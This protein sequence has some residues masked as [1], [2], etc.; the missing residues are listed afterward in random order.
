MHLVGFIIR[1]RLITLKFLKYKLA[2]HIV[3][4]FNFK[5][6]PRGGGADLSFHLG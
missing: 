1:M 6:L 4:M 2:V 3:M 5:L